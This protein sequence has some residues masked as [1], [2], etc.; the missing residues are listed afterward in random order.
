MILLKWKFPLLFL[1]LVGLGFSLYSYHKKVVED[2]NRRIDSQSTM[3]KAKDREITNLLGRVE[4]SIQGLTYSALDVCDRN[5]C[6]FKGPESLVGYA[7]LEGYYTTADRVDWGDVS[8]KCDVLTVTGGSKSLISDFIDWVKSGNA[9]NRLDSKQNL[10]LNIFLDNLS[11]QERLKIK[12]S[13]PANPVV[14]RVIRTIP[15]G[16]A[17]GSCFSFVDIIT[18]Q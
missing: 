12:K 17:A 6:L 14:L 18:V 1:I 16:R 4:N 8:V 11:D 5:E 3:I 10:L 13:S 9:V 2:F 7:V 15:Q